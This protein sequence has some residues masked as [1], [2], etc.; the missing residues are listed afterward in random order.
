M[1]PF[2]LSL[3]TTDLPA[4]RRFYV[5]VLGCS[6]ARVGPDFA[7]FDFFGH[8]LTF[9]Q[10]AEGLRLGFE[11]LHFGAVIAEP[12]FQDLRARLEQAGVPFVVAP[13]QQAQGTPDARWKMVFLDPSA[14]A[15]ELK[16]Y[17]DPSRLLASAAAYPRVR[18][19]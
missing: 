15:I 7:D 18:S 1:E 3:I 11:T 12:L 10:R 8:Q 6:P 19:R 5:E 17:T 14:Y 13:Q 2:H 4:Q 16:C 9:H